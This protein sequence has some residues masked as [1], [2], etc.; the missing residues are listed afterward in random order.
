[1]WHSPRRSPCIHAILNTYYLLFPNADND[2]GALDY[3]YEDLAAARS[4][5]TYIL[6]NL[7]TFDHKQKKNSVFVKDEYSNSFID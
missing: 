1:M 2:N 5:F 3:C 7:K 6:K 4:W